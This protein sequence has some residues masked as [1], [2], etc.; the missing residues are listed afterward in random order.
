MTNLAVCLEQTG[1][2]A[3]VMHQSNGMKPQI[4]P[5]HGGWA[6]LGDGWT[7]YGQTRHDALEAYRLARKAGKRRRGVT[8]AARN[9]TVKRRG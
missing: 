7:A 4:E 1:V 2:G 5:L 3:G 9:R 8:M 6:A